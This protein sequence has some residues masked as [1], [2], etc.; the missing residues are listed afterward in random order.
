MSNFRKQIGLNRAFLV[1]QPS[2]PLVGMLLGTIQPAILQC[3][4]LLPYVG[5]SYASN[6]IDVLS[7][8]SE[9]FKCWLQ[10]GSKFVF[11]FAREEVCRRCTLK[12]KEVTIYILVR[13]NI[14]TTL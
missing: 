10:S 11:A 12:T 3:H 9:V 14:Q 7:A 8:V 5:N 4:A 13:H 2:T 6:H 1:G